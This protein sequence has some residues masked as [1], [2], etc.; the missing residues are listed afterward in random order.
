[1]TKNA[2]RMKV[3]ASETV[4]VGINIQLFVV[5]DHGAILFGFFNNGEELFFNGRIVHL[6]VVE[7]A[8]AKGN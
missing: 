7:I 6:N 2:I 3:D 4:V 5:K 1:M 8:R